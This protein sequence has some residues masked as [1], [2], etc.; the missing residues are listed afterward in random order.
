[1][2][3]PNEPPRRYKWPWLVAAAVVLGILLAVVWVA[4]AVKKIERERDWNTPLSGNAPAR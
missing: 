4:I 3:E 2:D 1:M